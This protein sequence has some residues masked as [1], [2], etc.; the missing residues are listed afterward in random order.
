M[1]P[2]KW[3]RKEIREVF[4]HTD[5][6]SPGFIPDVVGAIMGFATLH[7]ERK[8]R[9]ITPWHIDAIWQAQM[10]VDFPAEV[11]RGIWQED[12]QHYEQ[13]YIKVSLK[14]WR[15]VSRCLEERQKEDAHV[16][17]QT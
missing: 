8:D 12:V 16:T 17:A 11:N 7:W 2:P 13:S 15:E 3:V 10:L 1:R 9:P 4:S 6:T 5:P 14:A